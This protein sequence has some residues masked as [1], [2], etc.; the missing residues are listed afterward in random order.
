MSDS[1]DNLAAEKTLLAEASQ[2]PL[3]S[4]WGT[5]AKLSGPGWLQGAIT[6]GGGSLAGSLYIGVIGGYELLWLQP[7]MMIFG[8]LMLSVIGYVTLSTGEKPFRAINKHINPV[9]GWGWL[10]A[11]MLA[12]LVWAMPQFSLGTAAIQQNFGILDGDNGKYWCALLLFVIGAAVVW[13]YD[14]GSKGVKVFEIILKIM[15]A[16]VVVS[17][18]GVVVAMSGSLDWGAIFTGF[19]P[20]FSLLS[21]PASKFTEIIAKSSDPGYWNDVILSSQRDRMVTAAATAV[22]INMT[23]LLPYSMLRKGWGKEHRGLAT[24]DLSLGLFLPFFLATTCVV[25][26]SASQFHGEYDKG[27]LDPA[28]RTALTEKLQGAYDKNLSGIQAK[29][30]EAKEPNDMDKQL[31]AM[32][33]SRDAFQLAGSLEKLTGNKAVTQTVFGIGVLGMAVSTIIILMLINGFTVTEMLGAEIG[34]MK[35]RIGSILPGITGALGFL[36]LWGDGDA[37]F[38]LAVPTSVFGMVLLPIAYITFFLMIN[39]KSLMGDALPQGNKRIALNIAMLVA[40]DRR[41]HRCRLVNMEQSA[42]DWRD[43]CGCV[44][45]GSSLRSLYASPS[46]LIGKSMG[47]LD[48]FGAKNPEPGESGHFGDYDL[49]E[50][51]NSGGMADIWLATNPDKRPVAVRRLHPEL[52]RDSTA[53]KRFVRG[54]EILAEVC[55]H[56]CIVNYIEHG[57]IKGDHFLAMEY[58]EFPNLKILISRS[59]TVLE[60][61][62]GNIL[63]DV[64]EALEH[65]HNCGYLHYDFKPENILVSRNGN[66]RLCDFDLSRPIPE[67]PTKMPDNP[68]TPVYMAPEQ[69]RGREIDQRVDIFAFGVTM[70]E[71]LT[72]KKPFNG[73]TSREV[74]L[75]QKNR[76]SHFAAPRDLNPS[77]PAAVES[78]ILQCIEFDADK[79]YPHISY[80]VAGLRKALYV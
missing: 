23:F 75:A 46:I 62:V 34:G 55:D 15:V 43:R 67:K 52:R 17:F 69:L 18:F 64:A 30:G 58:C 49:Q 41:H 76:D 65:V 36:F 53:R 38:W 6:L 13:S 44:C 80:L 39:S 54:C 79:R 37:R 9:L 42:V 26:A 47:L 45:F 66:V 51:V 21:E 74:L 33:V 31:A 63:I 48:I 50:V 4:R 25:I 40:L 19:I 32:L 57:K 5:F 60:K 78:I 14:S 28:K 35:H 70:Y 27:L 3:L 56:D 11:A 8:V 61:F 77:I 24:F 22:G 20:N 10:I 2:K 68:G 7:L 16:I 59:D 12:N 71:T 72:G 29:L 73:D 1:N